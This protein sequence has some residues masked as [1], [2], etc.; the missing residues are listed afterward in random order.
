M[1]A[2]RQQTPHQTDKG[3]LACARIAKLALWWRGCRCRRGK[4]EAADV[5]AEAVEHAK[6]RERRDGGMPG[7]S[8]VLGHDANELPM[9][10]EEATAREP[11]AGKFH[12]VHLDEVIANDYARGLLVVREGPN[13]ANRLPSEADER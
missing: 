5:G 6:V 12:R 3:A 7:G 8:V 2:S 1:G 4:A 13:A 11:R 9:L 10:V